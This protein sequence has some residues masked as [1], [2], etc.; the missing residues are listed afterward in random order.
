MPGGGGEA[1]HGQGAA[2][3]V[4]GGVAHLGAGQRGVAEVVMGRDA[5]VPLVAGVAVACADA[6]Q[7]EGSGLVE[8]GR[9]RQ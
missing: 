9:R 1:E 3:A 2:G 7:V 6:D 8:S 5:S 4:V